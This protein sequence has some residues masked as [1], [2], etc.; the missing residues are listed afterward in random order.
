M[1]SN[2]LNGPPAH[3]EA[4]RSINLSTI[5]PPTS[6]NVVQ[7][8]TTEDETLHGVPVI[9]LDNETSS[10]SDIIM[11][12]TQH[13]QSDLPRPQE[14][15]RNGVG[16]STLTRENNHSN[17]GFYAQHPISRTVG[18]HVHYYGPEIS[19]Q[20]PSHPYRRSDGSNILYATV[21][22]QRSVHVGQHACSGQRMY[23]DQQSHPAQSAYSGQYGHSS[24]RMFGGFPVR[25][26]RS[27]PAGQPFAPH[28]THLSNHSFSRPHF[29]GQPPGSTGAHIAEIV[30]LSDEEDN[31]EII[32]LSNVADSKNSR[33]VPSTS[34]RIPKAKP[35]RYANHSALE[36]R[37]KHVATYPE[38]QISPLR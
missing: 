10:E 33:R 26:G 36:S 14:Q 2:H 19:T 5:D 13:R 1:T 38:S 28:R 35:R 32:D 11:L 12:S 30:D 17:H 8:L 15:I 18:P 9:D 16:Q 21:G 23:S 31:V 29:I 27:V 6:E 24:P 20:S 3:T 4:P 22:G 25:M 37:T 7:D 34:L